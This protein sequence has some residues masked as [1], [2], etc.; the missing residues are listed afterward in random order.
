MFTMCGASGINLKFFTAAL[1]LQLKL[2]L[3]ANKYQ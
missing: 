2:N 1:I 3:I